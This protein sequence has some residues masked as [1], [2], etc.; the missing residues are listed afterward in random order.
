[1]GLLAGLLALFLTGAVYAMEDMFHRLPIHWMWWPA[2]GGLV[3]GIGGY[4]QPHAL[5][6][7]YDLIRGLLQGN[8]ALV[9][10]AD[11]EHITR[12]LLALIAVKCVI[13][14]VALGSGTSGGVLAPLLIMGG[15]LGAVLSPWLPSGDGPLWALV[16]MAAVLGGTM[17]SP[18]TG[19]VF[20]L[21]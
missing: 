13:W 15:A 3:V 10:G 17:R 18:L 2:L 12:A 1:L 4:F 11:P 14:S 6:V 20:A 7:G 16:S 21:E 5:G 8:T 19:T 9:L